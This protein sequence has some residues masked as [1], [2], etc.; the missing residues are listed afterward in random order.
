M[1]KLRRRERE[2]LKQLVADSILNRFTTDETIDYI[3]RVLHVKFKENYIQ[4]VK[5]WLREDMQEQFCELR[6][7]KFAYIHEYLNRINEL[8][9][10]QRQNHILLAKSSDANLQHRCMIELHSLT[11]SLANLYDALPAITE[12]S[13]YEGILPANNEMVREEAQQQE[14]SNGL[15]LT[16]TGPDT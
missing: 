8:K 4:K 5:K 9:E 12:R 11:V 3:D 16:D 2:K 1:T 13:F 7:D 14:D 6:R 15:T 10:L